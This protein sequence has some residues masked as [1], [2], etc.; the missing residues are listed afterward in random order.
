MTETKNFNSSKIGKITSVELN[1]TSASGKSKNH[2]LN[3]YILDPITGTE[4]GIRIIINTEAKR[5]D[6][7]TK[8]FVV[9][10]KAALKGDIFLKGVRQEGSYLSRSYTFHQV[11]DLFPNVKKIF[12][13]DKE[14]NEK[15][16]NSIKVAKKVIEV[17]T[18]EDLF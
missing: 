9:D 15:P 12:T 3:G 2:M 14:G 10:D 6:P 8:K 17:D 13:L 5:Y 11:S 7:K 4:I 18:T 16:T 1:R